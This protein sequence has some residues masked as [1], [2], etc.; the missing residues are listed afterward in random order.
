MK[1]KKESV[2]RTDGGVEKLTPPHI[3]ILYFT[4]IL[5]SCTCPKLKGMSSQSVILYSCLGFFYQIG[6]VTQEG[7]LTRKGA[8]CSMQQVWEELTGKH[9]CNICDICTH[10]TDSHLLSK[11]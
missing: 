10:G 3:L 2:R 11:Q 9:G 7:D 4:V 6:G 1:L 5:Y 8:S